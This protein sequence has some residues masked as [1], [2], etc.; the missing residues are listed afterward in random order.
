MAADPFVL[1]FESLKAWCQRQSY[2]FSEKADVGQLAVHYQ[3]LG[4]PAPLLI[5]PQR[6]R[7]MVMFVMRQPYTVPADRR[8][9]IAEACGLLNASMFM[10]AWAMNR[11]TGELYLR[12]TLPVVDVQYTDAG[13]LHVARVVVGTSEKAAPALRSIAL[14]GADPAKA[15]AA[16]H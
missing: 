2:Q 10:G 5:L 13:V 7:D 6:G 12:A 11:D 3:L 8:T 1:S 9:A 15:L 14:E 16:L 4:Q